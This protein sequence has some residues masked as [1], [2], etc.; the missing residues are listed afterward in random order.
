MVLFF[1][2]S[3]SSS[4][5]AL[6]TLFTA[7]A[8]LVLG[9]AVVARARAS[10]VSRLFFAIALGAAG[11]L[12]AFSAIYESDDFGRALLWARI[13][14]VFA[15]LIPAII[16]HFTAVYVGRRQEL[17]GAILFCWVFCGAIVVVGTTT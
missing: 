5:H 2:G 14:F 6:A 4:G 16:F 10:L 3:Q 1:P 13:A 9:L 15:S 17:R 7:A 12:G 11:W 8:V